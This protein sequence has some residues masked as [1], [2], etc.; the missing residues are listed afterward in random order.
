MTTIRLALLAA[1]GLAMTLAGSGRV[2]VAAPFCL[3]ALLTTGELLLRAL[4]GPPVP[5]AP[6]VPGAAGVPGARLA[7]AAL[8]GLVTLPLVALVLHAI[9]TPVRSVP[10]VAGIAVAATLATAGA[11]LRERWTA[12]AAATAGDD[13]AGDGVAVAAGR[14]SWVGDGVAVA[15][16]VLL[17]VVIGGVAT[18]VYV[19]SPRPEQP[20]YL[21]VALNG[22]AAGIS[23]PVTVPV[24]GLAVPIRVTSAGLATVTIPL[25]LRVGGRLITARPVT[26]GADTVRSLTVNLPALPPDG[27]LRA[28]SISVGS[29]STGFY[30]RGPVRG[31]RVTAGA[32]ASITGPGA[33]A[34]RL[35]IAPGTVAPGATARGTATRGTV[36]PGTAA[37]GVGAAWT[38][39]GVRGRTTC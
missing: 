29:T 25:R 34:H 27:C 10:L 3:V 4:P 2:A 11:L 28:V 38:G 13:A 32:R 36:T 33:G 17:A 16:P 6:G 24:R 26:V 18:R 35:P 23:A 21:S 8:A 9:G 37:R 22:W 15:V 39:A 20:G 5:E 30:A 12:R 31:A 1:A 14:R 19:A 7:L